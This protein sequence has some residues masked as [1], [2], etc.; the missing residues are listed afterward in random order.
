MSQVIGQITWVYTHDLER[1]LTFWRDAL[2]LRIVRDAGAAV[3]FETVP[4]ARIG[5]C[6]AFDGRVVQP[7]GS[8]ITLLVADSDQVDEW[9]RQLCDLDV[10]SRGAPQVLKA[11]NI[12][13]FFCEDPNGYVV[14]IQCF[15]D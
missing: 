4:G 7:E 8:M 10:P 1:S 14:E 12:Y 5:V 13:S 15:L 9:Y 2:G 6:T 11:F 3:I